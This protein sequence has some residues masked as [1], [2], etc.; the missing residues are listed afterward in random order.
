M[1]RVSTSRKFY[2]NSRSLQVTT[3]FLRCE[4]GE[5]DPQK[6]RY[7]THHENAPDS[8]HPIGMRLTVT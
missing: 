8:S 3:P 6:L 1:E 2:I 7:N 4:Q 5:A